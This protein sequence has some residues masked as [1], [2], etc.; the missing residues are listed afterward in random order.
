MARPATSR[1]GA[2]DPDDDLDQ[3]GL[4]E[5]L[6]AGLAALQPAIGAALDGASRDALIR[7]VLLLARWNRAYNLTA[8]RAPSA[9]ISR[10]L[11]DSLAVLPWVKEG[12]V[13]DIGTGAGL[14]GI[15]LALACPQLDF[16]LL[17]ANGKK[18]RFVRQAI[19]ELGLAR[20]EVVHARAEAYRPQR[21]FAT[22]VARAVASLETLRANSVHLAAVGGRLL[23]L[24]G[25]PPTDEIETLAATMQGTHGPPQIRTHRLEVPFAGGERN[26]IEIPFGTNAHG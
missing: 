2:S 4:R 17:D 7:F 6:D 25:R 19:L 10:H 9:M 15:P 11:L 21:K 26:L 23:A 22:I 20:V 12:P 1:A 3:A 8:I 14:P 24:K 13:L 5:Q 16:T 18:V